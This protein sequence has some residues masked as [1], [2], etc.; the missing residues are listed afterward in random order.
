MQEFRDKFVTVN[1]MTNI[2]EEFDGNGE[3]NSKRCA[4]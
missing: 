4:E 3:R 2:L 1:A